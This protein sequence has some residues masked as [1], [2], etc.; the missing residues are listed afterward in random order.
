MRNNFGA[1]LCRYSNTGRQEVPLG[2]PLWKKQDLF[3][4]E[5]VFFLG[6]K[7]GLSRPANGGIQIRLGTPGTYQR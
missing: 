6:V 2:T 5:Q 7:G 4:I 1:L 3:F